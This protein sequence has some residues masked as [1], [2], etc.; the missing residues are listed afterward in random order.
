MKEDNGEH[1][2][3]YFRQH[4]EDVEVKFNAMHWNKLSE[5]LVTAGATAAA[6]GD[7][8][9]FGKKLLKWI[10]TQKIW[11]AVGLSTVL[12]VMAMLWMRTES[13]QVREEKLPLLQVI[14]SVHKTN[15]TLKA[16]SIKLIQQRLE[17]DTVEINGLVD[18]VVPFKMML[19]SL[20]SMK[21]DSVKNPLD[22]FIFW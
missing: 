13:I 9:S 14:D 8:L 7:S 19:D 20:D 6:A 11:M 15:V 22:H 17:R 16:D 12:V 3:Q 21:V 2:D 5:V 10:R 18:S 4:Y 1:I